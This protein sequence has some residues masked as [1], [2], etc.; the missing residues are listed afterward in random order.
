MSEPICCTPRSLPD[1]LLVQAA[2]SAVR[3]NPLNRPP[4]PALATILPTGTPDPASIA[5][6]TSKYWHTNGV[7]LS[8]GFLDN[9]PQALRQRILSHMNAWGQTANVA[10]SETSSDPQVRITRT[11]GGGHWSYLGTDILQIGPGDPTM[12]LDSF[13]M[14]T[15]D[16]EFYRVVRHETGHTLG[17]PHEHLRQQ[18]VDLI[19]PD[20]AI[21]F[22]GA[23]QG[24]PPAQ[25]RAQVL[26]PLSQASI[27]GT[28]NADQNSIMCYQI[29][30]S[31]TTSGQ[32]ILGGTDIDATDYAFMATV[33]PK[34]SAAAASAPVSAP[35]GAHR[36]AGAPAHSPAAELDFPDGR[37]L[38]LFRPLAPTD[39][40]V[41]IGSSAPSGS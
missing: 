16:S 13:T 22:Y 2:D 31:I 4:V 39:L 35:A 36:P 26:T 34:P 11:P 37:R 23:T 6:L 15:P 14:Q 17:C 40:G 41:L 33:Y 20:K 7:H 1:T 25:V 28:P 29:P 12:N 24:W 18:L 21:A 3:I 30:G 38:R 8:V 27:M 9:P 5:V 19:D 10:F 32:P